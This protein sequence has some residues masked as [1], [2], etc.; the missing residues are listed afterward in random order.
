MALRIDDVDLQRD[1]MLVE[2]FQEGDSTAFDTLYRRYF[3]RLQRFCL[4]RVGDPHEAEEI[5]QEAFAKAYR[6]LPSLGGDRRFYPWMTVIAGRLCVDHHRRRGRSE[7]AAVIDLGSVDGGQDAIVE[8]A[9]LALLAL[10]MEGLAPRHREV[11]DMRERLGWSYQQ[12]ADH[13]EVP[14]GTVE[15]LLFRARKALKREFLAVAGSDRLGGLAALPVLGGLLRRWGAVKAKVG[16]W[17]SALPTAAA[18]ALSV[19]VAVTSVA[20]VGTAVLEAGEPAARPAAVIRVV[21]AGV[22]VS[23]VS[24]TGHAHEQE[25]SDAGRGAGDG[26][27][28]G[29]TSGG[30]TAAPDGGSVVE[31]VV[32]V[33]SGAAAAVEVH[34]D[35]SDAARDGADDQPFF[36]DIADDLVF[37]GVDPGA[38]SNDIADAGER[39]A[40][41]AQHD[42][43]PYL[44]EAGDKGSDE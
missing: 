2:R 20:A 17:A 24:E 29:A 19:A 40:V 8:Q 5:A 26:R 4:K 41:E 27:R 7:P 28:G 42:A 6:A 10:A 36:Y 1:R 3:A 25:S 22:P 32:G 33:G 11:L 13:W 18:P 37:T 23:V 16:A 39:Y 43:Q 34:T 15:A 38:A 30:A 12:I 21:G 9:D 35:D 44:A 14:V 31:D